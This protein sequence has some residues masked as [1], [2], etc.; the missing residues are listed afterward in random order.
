MSAA[1]LLTCHRKVR[2]SRERSPM[3][4]NGRLIDGLR[5]V[6]GRTRTDTCGVSRKHTNQASSVERI[7]PISP[8][9]SAV[10]EPYWGKPDVR[11]DEGDQRTASWRR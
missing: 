10:G 5:V 8:S 7:Y 11:F 3:M 1:R 6:V 4:R 9:G 2:S